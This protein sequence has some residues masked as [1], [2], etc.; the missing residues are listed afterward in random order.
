MKAV[1]QR[2][3]RAEVRVDGASVGAIGAGLVVLLGVLKGDLPADADRLAERTAKLRIFNDDAGKMNR[4]MLEAAG[5][6]LVVS[7]FTLAGSVQRGL[8]PSFDDAAPPETAEGL[9]RR[10]VE[11][12]R[13]L[14]PR[15]A[16]GTF[17]AMMEVELVGDGPV[18]FILEE[19]KPRFS[20]PLA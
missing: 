1:L 8:R 12:L 6:A 10:Y 4:S 18:T 3:S 17:R 19:P 13:A 11:S 7:Q 5:E 9:Y 20:E 16:T 14:G 2:V 15:V